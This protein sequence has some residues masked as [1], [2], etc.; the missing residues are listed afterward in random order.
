MYE[1][2]YYI[3]GKQVNLGELITELEKFK[4][5]KMDSPGSFTIKQLLSIER[6]DHF[7]NTSPLFIL[8]YK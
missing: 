5:T 4:P 3:N 7:C 8:L 6:I 2:R 1:D